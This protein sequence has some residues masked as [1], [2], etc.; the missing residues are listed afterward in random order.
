MQIP[1]V[2]G[3]YKTK[4]GKLTVVVNRRTITIESEKQPEYTIIDDENQPPRKR[5]GNATTSPL[6]KM[7]KGFTDLS[8]MLIGE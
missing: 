7:G 1:N 8:Y 2:D 5:G 4:D 3:N 6:R